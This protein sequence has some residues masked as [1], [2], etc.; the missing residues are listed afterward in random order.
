MLRQHVVV[1][2]CRARLDGPLWRRGL[3]LL[4]M[5]FHRTRRIHVALGSTLD[6][7]VLDLTPDGDRVWGWDAFCLRH[8]CVPLYISVDGDFDPEQWARPRVPTW[9]SDLWSM[10]CR[11]VTSGRLGRN[12]PDCV[13]HAVQI[14]RGYGVPVPRRIV[15]AP[16]LEGW[17]RA[18]RQQA[19]WESA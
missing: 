12:S 6:W 17:L 8:D 1:F 13:H 10:A 18:H 7:T 5:L 2:F 4:A 3:T 11:F 15:T 19:A 9:C 16:Q 14:L